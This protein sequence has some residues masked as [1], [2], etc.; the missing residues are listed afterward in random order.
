[1]SGSPALDRS[2]LSVYERRWGASR[3]VVQVRPHLWRELGA[4]VPGEAVLEIGPGLRPAAPVGTACFLET[5]RAAVQSLRRAGARTI[6]GTGT[7]LP[8]RTQTFDA[9]LAFEV[10][11]HIPDDER[12]LG[13]IGRVL[14]PG[15]LLALSVPLH[16]ALWSELDDACAHVRRY[17]PAELWEKL[18]A[19]GMEPQRYELHGSFRRA[20]LARVRTTVLARLPRASNF[21]LQTAAFPLQRTWQ[22]AVGKCRWSDAREPIR[23]GG[24]GVTVLATA[25]GDSAKA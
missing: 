5:S 19:A 12:V 20:K 25:S 11:E 15:G 18:R 8:F 16:A 2:P 1:M 22:E 7:A 9:V 3:R 10:L 17:E 21:L 6:Q 13:E 23:N 14:R 24:A 4:A